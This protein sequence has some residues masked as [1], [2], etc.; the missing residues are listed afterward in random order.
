[1]QDTKISNSSA[2]IISTNQDLLTQILVRLPVKPLLRFKSVSKYWL[3]LISSPQFSA[4]HTLRRSPKPAVSGLILRK[5][6]SEFKLLSFNSDSVSGSSLLSLHFLNGLKIIQSCNGLL[7]CS[8]LPQV[9]TKRKYYVSNPTTKQLSALPPLGTDSPSVT[10]FG[11]NLAFDPSKSCNYKIICV[12]STEFSLYH[13]QIELYDSEIGAW[14]LS[15]S[16]FVAPFDLVF[17]N[18]VFWNGAVHWISPTGRGLYFD[19]DKELIEAIPYLPSPSSWAKRR[20]RTPEMAEEQ[21]VPVKLFRKWDSPY[22]VTV[23]VALRIKEPTFQYIEEDLS[24]DSQIAKYDP[25]FKKT[26]VL[27]HNGKPI[28]ELLVIIEYIDETWTDSPLL[29]KDPYA[30]AKARFWAKYVV[31]KVYPLGTKV[32][33]AKGKEE[34]EKVIEEVYQ[35]LDRL[36][37]LLQVQGESYAFFG[38][39]EI[40]LVDVVAFGI[41]YEFTMIGKALEVELIPIEKFRSLG[42]W[43]GFLFEVSLFT[44]Y[45]PIEDEHVAAIKARHEAAQSA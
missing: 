13:Y 19:V 41:A 17:D 31:E 28:E 33:E 3:S 7:L 38:V 1:M 14:R 44:D 23:Q 18:A 15:G 6:P 16:P 40:G 39:G 12:R 8:T 25:V 24:D 32:I 36:D 43:L 26:P 37:D 29:P 30:R 22:T 5:S 35:H 2:E 11:F 34:Q 9:G 4:A 21:D 10:I 45:L 42:M 27:I 20:F